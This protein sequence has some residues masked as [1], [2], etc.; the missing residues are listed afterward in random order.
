MEITLATFKTY[1]PAVTLDDVTLQRYLNDAKRNCL[2]DGVK[3]D[4]DDFDELQRLNALSQMQLDKIPGIVSIMPTGTNIEDIT[5]MNV[6]GI[7]LSFN[8]PPAGVGLYVNSLGHTGYLA[9]YE[10]LLY[11]VLGSRSVVA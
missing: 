6:A 7:G 9:Q 10:D 2:R 1:I 4:N 11:K 5:N 8:R 3:L